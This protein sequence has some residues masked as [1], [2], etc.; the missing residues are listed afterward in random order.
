MFSVNADFRI[1]WETG[2][3]FYWESLSGKIVPGLVLVLCCVW[4][5]S[6]ETQIAIVASE[7][8]RLLQCFHQQL[9]GLQSIGCSCENSA[10]ASIVVIISEHSLTIFIF[11]RHRVAIVAAKK[12][13]GIQWWSSSCCF[14]REV[15][16][17][18][19]SQAFSFSETFRKSEPATFSQSFSLT[20]T[21]RK[22]KPETF[23]QSFFLSETF[24]KSE[25]A[26]C[27]KTFKLL[28]FDGSR[29]CAFS[30]TKQVKVKKGASHVLSLRENKGKLK[31]EP[32]TYFLSKK[33][34]ES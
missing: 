25:P 23:S 26:T 13:D 27:S 1:K 31:R 16:P 8:A 33:T 22:S 18:T 5:K 14:W 24:R 17:A 32:A 7:K 10:C 6:G 15:Q 9:L 11:L 30:Q 4:G 3:N 21:F 19:F 12:V 29:P 34:R 20:E 2:Y 28:Y